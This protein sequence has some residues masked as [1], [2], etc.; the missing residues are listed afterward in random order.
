MAASKVGRT[1]TSPTKRQTKEKAVDQVI[2]TNLAEHDY[3][4]MA[5]EKAKADAL[6]AETRVILKQQIEDK[7]SRQNQARQEDIQESTLVDIGIGVFSHRP[8]RNFDQRDDIHLKNTLKS[9]DNHEE[10]KID[11]HLA[12]RLESFD[13]LKS[14]QE[15]RFKE[16][17]KTGL[18][19]GLDAQCEELAERD[20]V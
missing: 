12:H 15:Y 3:N 18:K 16:A 13:R 19:Q 14:Q 20:Y 10:K 4:V 9:I 5:F 1:R 2:V 8:L 11:Q 7:R 17:Q 6:K